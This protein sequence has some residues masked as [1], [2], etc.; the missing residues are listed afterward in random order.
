MCREEVK[1]AIDKFKCGEA[2]SVDEITA[3]KLKYRGKKVIE[4]MFMIQ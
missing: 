1:K 3:E 4:W 2:V